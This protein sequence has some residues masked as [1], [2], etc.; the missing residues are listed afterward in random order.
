MQN[1]RKDLPIR[2]D[3]SPIVERLLDSIV[4]HSL[5]LT[6]LQ[7]RKTL[8]Q[9]AAQER[10]QRDGRQQDIADETGNDS[11]ECGSEDE[12]YSH[13]KHVVSESKIAEVVPSAAQC[14]AGRGCGG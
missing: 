13:F 14:P 12:S 2:H 1:R 11:T 10:Q 3:N 6:M 9:I 8:I 4:P 5:V 7:G